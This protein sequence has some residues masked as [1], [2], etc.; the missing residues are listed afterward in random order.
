MTSPKGS[1]TS[2]IAA[3]VL[4]MYLSLPRPASAGPPFE[5]DDPEPVDCHHVEIDVA[6][7]RQSE[8]ART[9]PIWEVDYGP[10]KN[11]ELSVGGQP[12]E[13]E[14]A[15]AIRF[16]PETKYTPQVG[17]LPALTVN[18]NGETETFMP[19]WAQKTIGQWTV[20]GGGGVSHG[21]EFTGVTVMHNSR[22]GSSL[23]LEFYHESQHNPILPAAPRVGLGYV[24]QVAPSHAFMFWVGRQL[25]PAPSY[26]F[27]IGVQGIIAPKSTGANCR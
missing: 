2:V 25:Q 26:Y 24:D 7:G 21:D 27:Y 11:V 18:A 20:F 9:G 16:L 22:S 17:F 5:T 15:S 1:A 3:V 6:Q 23:G 12:G 13:L 8:P 19:F 4:A 10:T 14:L